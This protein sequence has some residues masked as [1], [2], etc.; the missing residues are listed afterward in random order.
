M[1]AREPCWNCAIW[2]CICGESAPRV[3]PFIADERE[4][5]DIALLPA[6]RLQGSLNPVKGGGHQLPAF[7]RFHPFHS[8]GDTCA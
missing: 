3:P 1:T 2:P 7:A 4:G 6:M 8:P 5:V